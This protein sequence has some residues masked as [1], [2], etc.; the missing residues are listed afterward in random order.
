MFR[1]CYAR[2]VTSVDADALGVVSPI[3]RRYINA[4]ERYIHRL[5]FL[6]LLSLSLLERDM[7]K[8]VS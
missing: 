7:P 5:V 3:T 6:L 2:F 4:M 8:M 1:I